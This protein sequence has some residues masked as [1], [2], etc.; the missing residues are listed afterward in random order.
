MPFNK[1]NPPAPP[2]SGKFEIMGAPAR[3]SVRD[4][5]LIVER[6]IVGGK[7]DDADSYAEVFFVHVDGIAAALRAARN[8]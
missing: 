1:P 8:D 4:N 7:E 6:M 2:T 3:W 5:L